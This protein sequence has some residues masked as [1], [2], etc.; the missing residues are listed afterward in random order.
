MKER[1]T[2]P[3]E[4]LE[5]ALN[6]ARNGQILNLAIAEYG[7]SAKG[8][9]RQIRVSMHNPDDDTLAL[10]AMHGGLGKLQQLCL[11]DIETT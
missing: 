2:T 8:P 6:R 10:L 11:D 7:P 3:I 1:D 9:Q 4:L 5:L